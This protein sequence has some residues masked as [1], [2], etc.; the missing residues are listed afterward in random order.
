MASPKKVLILAR[1]DHAEAMR[2]AAGMTIAD[3]Q[4]RLIFMS[5]PVAETPENAEQAETLELAGIVP[6]TTVQ[7]MGDELSL[8]DSAAL[9]RAIGESDRVISI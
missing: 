5:G 2:I 8:L 6:E 1:R 4:V 9:A 3:H 7:E